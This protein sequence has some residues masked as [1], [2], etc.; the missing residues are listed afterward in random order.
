MADVPGGERRAPRMAD[1]RLESR[2]RAL[3]NGAGDGSTSGTAPVIGNASPLYGWDDQ[4]LV[5]GDIITPS[6]PTIT[7]AARSL[8]IAWDGLGTDGL[9]YDSSLR[10]EVHL[11]TSSGF[12]PSSSTLRGVLTAAGEVTVNGLTS[13]ATYW[14]ALRAVDAL[15][16]VQA[17]SSQVSA[18]VT[19]IVGTDIG[20]A[21]IQAG[22]VAFNARQIGGITTTV[23]TTAPTSPIVGDIW[24]DTSTA[25]SAGGGAVQK[26]YSGTAWVTQAWG[27]DALSANCITATQL[28]AGAITAGSAVIGTGAISSAQIGDLDAGKI[29]TGTL[30]GI[31]IQTKA[32]GSRIRLQDQ[33]AYGIADAVEFLNNSTKL[34]QMYVDSNECAFTVPGWMT[35]YNT[36]GIGNN[37]LGAYANLRV[38]TLNASTVN[39]PKVESDQF[40][41]Q[42]SGQNMTMMGTVDVTGGFFAAS[43]GSQRAF[44]VGAGGSVFSYGIN[45]NT[46]TNSANVRCGAS[47]QLL[48][49]T[50]TQRAKADI[51][52]IGKGVT[53]ANL[54]GVSKAKIHDGPLPAGNVNHSDVLKIVP[55]E[56]ASL[57]PVDNGARNFGFIAENV[58]AV[59]PWAAEWD[60]QGVPNAVAD[61]PIVAA[62]LAVVKEQQDRLSTLEARLTALEAKLT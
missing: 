28:A 4:D 37:S 22:N 40:S 16:T 3:G 34:G 44:R 1:A 55:T 60:P 10:V 43:S 15:G 59:F 13:G 33:A 2:L 53:K 62:L 17:S 52:P 20:Q 42:Q 32:N 8:A 58:A 19:L 56:F 27:A 61:R 39:T 49:S 54:E 46:T 5:T 29:T 30:T 24:I 6:N 48:L 7:S 25:G 23:G 36:Q 35:L 31:T 45:D 50:S 9:E 38:R 51:I 57:A 18:L 47:A 11:G 41:S 21:T 14:A 12:T 26:R